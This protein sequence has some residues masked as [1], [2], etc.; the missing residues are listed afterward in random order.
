MAPNVVVVFFAGAGRP[1]VV[2][3]GA[4]VETVASNRVDEVS[5]RNLIVVGKF[6]EGVAMGAEE[7][8][9]FGCEL[10]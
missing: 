6:Q 7:M 9:E 4:G 8:S 3:E 1:D 5:V 10:G 2:H